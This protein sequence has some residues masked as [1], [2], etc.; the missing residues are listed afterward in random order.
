MGLLL[1]AKWSK[2]KTNAPNDPPYQ[3]DI[4]VRD[5]T[6]SED[7]PF[8][9]FYDLY[10]ENED[11]RSIDG[12]RN[13]VQNI[14]VRLMRYATEDDLMYVVGLRCRLSWWYTDFYSEVIVILLCETFF[15]ENGPPRRIL[16]DGPSMMAS[17]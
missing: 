5:I 11:I 9:P 10:N 15:L 3:I 12:L 1:F 17:L 14:R 8:K 6:E 16:D 13:A 7:P 4:V 2:I